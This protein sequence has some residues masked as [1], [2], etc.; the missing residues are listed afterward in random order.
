MT[1]RLHV[2]FD[3][4]WLHRACDCNLANEIWFERTK[5]AYIFHSVYSVQCTLYTQCIHQAD[6]IIIIILLYKYFVN[7]RWFEAFML[8]Y[9]HWANQR[10]RNCVCSDLVLF[11]NFIVA[12]FSI[13]IKPI[14]NGQIIFIQFYNR[15]S[16]NQFRPSTENEFVGETIAHEN[17]K[18]RREETPKPKPKSI[19][20]TMQNNVRSFIRQLRSIWFRVDH[21]LR[22]SREWR[23]SHTTG[24]R[25]GND[26]EEFYDFLF[27]AT[28]FVGS[29][30]TNC[31]SFSQNQN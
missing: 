4:V 15:N 23:K 11:F 26:R 16:H 24:K 10:F 19:P 31:L 18:R 21:L 12:F 3:D 20:R 14:L 5:K 8:I 27:S 6:I 29:I 9:F 22:C 25:K 1:K 30:V 28:L 13:Q 7:D 2:S 17:K